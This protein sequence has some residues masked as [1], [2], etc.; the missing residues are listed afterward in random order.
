MRMR[1]LS[2]A[3]KKVLSFIFPDRQALTI[4]LFSLF[5]FLSL[6]SV[7][8]YLNDEM[9]QGV[10]FYNL[11]HGRLTVDEIPS[12]YYITPSGLHMAPRFTEYGGHKYIAASHGV[13]VFSLPFYYFLSLMNFIMGVENFFIV[14][15]SGIFAIMIF[16]IANKLFRKRKKLSWVSGI[17]AFISL[18]LT[19]LWFAQ[20]LGFN[21]WGAVVSIQ[22]MSIFFTS[23]AISVL[24]RFFRNCLH[25]RTALFGSLALAVSSPVAFW[26]IGQKYHALNMALFIFS[27]SSFYYGKNK[28][29]ERYHY[30]SYVFASLATWVQLFSGLVIL[31]S[32]LL[33]DVLTIKNQRMKNFLKIGLVILISLTPYFSENYIVYSNPLYPGYIAKGNKN[34]I[35]PSPPKI[36]IFSPKNG[37][38]ARGMIKIWYK[39]SE[40]AEASIVRYIKD[41][42]SIVINESRE[43]EVRLFW[44]TTCVDDG[45][46]MISIKA[47]NWRGDT[48]YEN[49]S[50][51]IDNTPPHIKIIS[52]EQNS[53]VAKKCRVMVNI[54][55]DVSYVLYEYSRDKNNWQLIENDSTPYD[56]IT[57]NISQLQGAY[58]L[59]AIA[60]DRVG[61]RDVDIIKIFIDNTRKQPIIISP[62][63]GEIIGGKYNLSVLSPYN[64]THVLYEYY[65]NGKWRKI[66]VNYH[67]S[68]PY[69]WDTREYGYAKIMIKA[70]AYSGNQ[71][72]GMDIRRN[73]TIDNR[74]PVI[75]ILSPAMGEKL[76]DFAIIEYNTSNNT[77]FVELQYSKDNKTWNKGGICFSGFLL[78]GIKGKIFVKVVAY[79]KAGLQNYDETHFE[80]LGK[81]RLTSFTKIVFIL[82]SIWIGLKFFEDRSAIGHLSDI[83]SRLYK[84]FFNAEGTE[85]SFAFFTFTPLLILSLF[86]PFIYLKKKKKIGLIEKLMI[87]YIFIHL[88]FFAE[89]S[90]QQGGG[91]DVRFYFPLHIPFMYFT[92]VSISGLIEKNFKS[93]LFSYALAIVFLFPAFVWF[94][95]STNFLGWFYIVKFTRIIA[96]GVLFS[97]VFIFSLFLLTKEKGKKLLS[98]C[99]ISFIGI[100]LFVSTW[101]L[102]IVMIV[103]SRGIYYMYVPDKKTFTMIIPFMK[104]V[105]NLLQNLLR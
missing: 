85:S 1:M 91:Y 89:M 97:L 30:L 51:F 16:L 17:I 65:L 94:L 60:C 6:L 41:N 12:Y 102:I 86:S 47:W 79:T 55:K 67:P 101:I 23:L 37:E 80:I 19:N 76:R 42:A 71:L 66:G 18:L 63:D 88:I 39:V 56:G 73:I 28:N 34:V 104:L 50:I 15:W 31:L 57:W 52:P 87:S 3:A 36:D 7:G 35:P 61:F 33:I 43:K 53:I 21:R 27:F 74:K 58:F 54:S 24:F 96:K 49:V 105:Q 2:N 29:N 98:P 77:A 22:F 20:P 11:L 78:T 8:F 32:L 44:N 70:I 4:F 46:G 100:S 93:I 83:P 14:L 40:N 69:A 72:V 38:F 13:A 81:K 59:K 62:Q 90:T 26:A 5:I 9:E 64:V 103:Y 45:I 84:S 95:L 99:L 10:C 25:E 92:L 75:K 48:S 68:A 82:H